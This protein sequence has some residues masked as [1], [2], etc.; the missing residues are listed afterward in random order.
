PFEGHY[1]LD[2]I[3]RTAVRML[4]T[5][6]RLLQWSP[7]SQ[8]D[9]NS[10][11]GLLAAFRW[12]WIAP[13]LSAAT[14]LYLLHA[15][16]AAL[17]AAAPV[18]LLWLSSPLLVWWLSRPLL[19]PRA[20]LAPGQ[21]AFLRQAARK[22][23]AFFDAF[24]G[25]DDHW[26]P[27]DNFQESPVKVL[28]RRTSPTN[29]GL[30]LLAN[31]SA[32]DFGYVAA[33][34]LLERTRNAFASM[35]QLQRHRGHFFNWYDTAS[36]QPLLPIYVSTVDSGNLA[37]H[38][39]TLRAG[40]AALADQPILAPRWLE[41]LEDTLRAYPQVAPPPQAGALGQFER[42]LASALAN[43]PSTLA[44]ARAALQGLAANAAQ[45]PELDR[46]CRQLLAELDLLAPAAVAQ[47][48]A[49]PTLRELAAQG[50]A[51]AC[52]RMAQLAQLVVQAG[53]MARM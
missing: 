34:N 5:R 31:L 26:L 18:L 52:E 39:L 16:P 22:S 30:G 37:G 9:G 2:A 3:L 35:Q 42:D 44:A 47:D 11:T 53:D 23:W 20:I 21:E 29:I 43:R 36:L 33:G 8:L 25:A 48:N 27:P 41:G 17:A 7:S 40:L 6:R 10:S 1:S 49:I 15:Q 38:L 50:A 51:P 19:R 46:Q 28:A 14:T 45:I 13:F 24:V 32:Y 12:M 4:L